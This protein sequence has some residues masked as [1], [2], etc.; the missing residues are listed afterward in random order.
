MKRLSSLL[1]ASV[2]LAL[3][4]AAA[5]A[6]KNLPKPL[7]VPDAKVKIDVAGLHGGRADVYD[8]VP[9]RGTLSPYVPGQKVVVTFYLDGHRLVSHQVAV[10]KGSGETGTFEA[11]VIVKED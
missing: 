4:A 10:D 8:T 9:V 6:P 1:A 7:P 5:A 11:S 3:P 2:V